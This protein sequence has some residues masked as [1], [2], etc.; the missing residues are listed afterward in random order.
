MYIQI[1][2]AG[3]IS[4]ILTILF[5]NLIQFTA[6]KGIVSNLFVNIRGGIPRGVG[7]AVLFSLIIFLPSPYNYVIFTMGA[8]AFVD[9]L[10]GRRKLRGIPLEIGQLCRGLGMILVAILGYP[11]FGYA[12]ILIAL[13]IQPLNISDMQ[14]GSTCS[15]VIIMLLLV[16]ALYLIGG[17]LNKSLYFIPLI[18]LA[19]CA[20]YAPLDYQGKI[21]MGEVGNHSFAII[22]G[23]IFFLYGG[24][25]G[26]LILSLTMVALIAFIRRKN[27]QNFLEDNLKIKNPT[28]GDY[29]MDVLTGGGLGELFRKILLGNR[30]ISVKNRILIKMGI[31]RLFHNSC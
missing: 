7:L 12:S 5:S 19:V 8:L 23:I 13:M 17:N 9:D 4:T 3:I 11:F 15:T 18:T 21:M 6:K 14:P 16:I 27:L 2:G 31:R 30:K 26:F 1:I 29:F 24:L 25:G 20:G 10:A 28:F 22:L